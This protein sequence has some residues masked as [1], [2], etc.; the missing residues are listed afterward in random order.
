MKA[1]TKEILRDLDQEVKVKGPRMVAEEIGV[2]EG[3][4]RELAPEESRR[5]DEVSKSNLIA[6]GK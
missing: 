1:Y 5:H 4:V 3:C 6:E 2:S